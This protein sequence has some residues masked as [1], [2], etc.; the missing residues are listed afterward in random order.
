[1]KI[2]HH[3]SLDISGALKNPKCLIN[4]ITYDGQIL[5]KEKQIIEFLE[6]QQYLG[7]KLL[8]L[9]ECEGFDYIK[10][11]PGH[12]IEEDGKDE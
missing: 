7:H 1:M 5:T 3:V 11:C 10:G 6:Y 9:G 12:I 8:P 2:I 4:A